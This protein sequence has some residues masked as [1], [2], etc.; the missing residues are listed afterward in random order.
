MTNITDNLCMQIIDD[1]LIY[2]LNSIDITDV[3][4]LFS[5]NESNNTNQ[6]NKE[7][8]NNKANNTYLMVN[9]KIKN[10]LD[11]LINSLSVIKHIL[12]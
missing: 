3:N 10:D 12:N 6:K 5:V 2:K 9:N 1:T 11:D 4:K 8:E 7:T